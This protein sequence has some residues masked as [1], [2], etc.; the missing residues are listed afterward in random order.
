MGKKKSTK[1]KNRKPGLSSQRRPARLKRLINA[2]HRQYGG[3]F[4]RLAES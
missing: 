4:R 3:V 1:S 2:A